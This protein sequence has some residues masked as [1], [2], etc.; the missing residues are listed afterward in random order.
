VKRTV[1][2]STTDPAIDQY[3]FAHTV[4]INKLTPAQGNLFVFLP[5]TWALGLAY[6]DILQT[7]ANLGIPAIGL[8]YPNWVEIDSTCKTANDLDCHKKI[9]TEIISGTNDSPVIV[10]NQINSISNRLVKLL[11]YL[12]N[13]YPVEGWGQFIN[14]YGGINWSNVVI[15]GH[16]QGAGHAAFIA[17]NHLV[18]RCLM[19]SWIDFSYTNNR[20]ALWVSKPGVTPAAAYYGFTHLDDKLVPYFLVYPPTWTA[21]GMDQFGPTISI[22]TSDQ[23]VTSSHMLVTNLPARKSAHGATV[24]DA[25]TPLA[26]DSIPVF[27]NAWRYMLVGWPMH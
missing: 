21:L 20:I 15:G 16:S 10:V 9:R 11:A 1:M 4:Y 14:V 24:V 8:T 26:A 18:H 2:P 23:F 17:K 27:A 19:F 3:D 13:Q 12:H 22:N 6:T 7:A 25:S 5:G